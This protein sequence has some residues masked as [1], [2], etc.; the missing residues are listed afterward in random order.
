MLALNVSAFP[1]AKKA[2][3]IEFDVALP[4]FHGLIGEDGQVQGMFE[5]A[6]V[7]YTGM[8]TM[9]SAVLM[10]KVATKRIACR[11]RYSATALSSRSSAR[12]KA[13]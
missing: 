5:A 7:P 10:D 4:C 9:A 6:R 3:P 8:R 11:R 12:A 1:F 2:K 13:C